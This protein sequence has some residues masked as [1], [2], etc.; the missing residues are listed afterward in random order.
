MWVLFADDTHNRAI[1]TQAVLRTVY[2]RVMQ[3]LVQQRNFLAVVAGSNY[4]NDMARAR[5][6]SKGSTLT[7]GALQKNTFGFDNALG[8]VMKLFEN[9]RLALP[10][11][12]VIPH[13]SFG[14]LKMCKPESRT[15]S[16]CGDLATRLDMS[17]TRDFVSN[18]YN[19]QFQIF[20]HRPMNI[21]QDSNEIN[22]LTRDRDVGNVFRI[23]RDATKYTGSG[24]STHGA[25]P[26][27]TQIVD[28]DKQRW[29][30]ITLVEALQHSGVFETAGVNK[31]KLKLD[32]KTN[33]GWFE[34]GATA[35]NDYWRFGDIKKEYLECMMGEVRR[36][37]AQFDRSHSQDAETVV[38]AALWGFSDPSRADTDKATAADPKKPTVTAA[39]I[40]GRISA[41]TIPEASVADV[42]SAIIGSA[43][44]SNDAIS[45]D[46]DVVSVGEELATVTTEQMPAR[47]R[48]ALVETIGSSGASL[49]S[50]SRK[51]VKSI[52]RNTNASK[53]GELKNKLLDAMKSD[54]R[55]GWSDLSKASRDA[56]RQNE[57]EIADAMSSAETAM[58]IGVSAN[59]TLFGD[60][61]ASKNNLWWWTEMPITIAAIRGLDEMGIVTPFGAY[62]FRP[63]QS[64]EM[65]SM[66]VVSFSCCAMQY[67]LSLT[68]FIVAQDESWY[69]YR[70]DCCGKFGF[71]AWR[72]CH[73][74]SGSS[75][76]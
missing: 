47:L 23:F 8:S 61:D 27:A 42:V 5:E 68:N 66:I 36:S 54:F 16:I 30:T 10:D 32:F 3:V 21:S 7:F 50:K 9:R 14:V 70:Y 35:T 57:I 46:G 31:G 13:G 24:I 73:V 51:V 6:I 41:N 25:M 52:A 71:P 38:K 40:G 2:A 28:H 45:A 72:F 65:G 76:P 11:A 49:F 64:F 58:P 48:G 67:F 4:S 53:A 75:V 69:R 22:M 1:I 29:R 33:S 20:E 26:T 60:A 34:S 37:V 18:I 12:V 15:Y 63:F 74:S 62:V 43:V 56:L 17:P 44:A 59:R 39:P 19:N 55:S